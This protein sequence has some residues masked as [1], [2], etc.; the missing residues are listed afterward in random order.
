M[1]EVKQKEKEEQATKRRSSKAV[2]KKH[3]KPSTN[4]HEEN[5][6]VEVQESAA[7]HEL[8]AVGSGVS[9]PTVEY[10]CLYCNEKY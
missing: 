5:E 7:V 6:N 9:K 10:F 8:A 2:S 1:K 3:K 4:T